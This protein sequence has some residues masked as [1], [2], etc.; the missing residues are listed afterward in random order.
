MPTKPY[1]RRAIREMRE[2]CDA[3]E[4]YESEAPR[5]NQEIWNV[6]VHAELV[7][8]SFGT[9]SLNGNLYMLKE[10]VKNYRKAI[11]SV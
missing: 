11:G 1:I 9:D 6:L 3:I 2:L 10:A 4:A 7:V 8:D 5:P